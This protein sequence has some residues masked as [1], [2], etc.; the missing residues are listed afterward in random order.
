[1]LDNGANFSDNSFI[2]GIFLWLGMVYEFDLLM[3]GLHPWLV[4]LYDLVIVEAS[5]L[6]FYGGDHPCIVYI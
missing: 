1:M 6:G 5:W 3:R 4:I 2:L